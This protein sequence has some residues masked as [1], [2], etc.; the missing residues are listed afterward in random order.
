[1]TRLRLKFVDE[2]GA[3][4]SVE[5]DRTPF[6]IGRHSACDLTYTD[7][8]LSR[9][10]LR[11]D[12]EGDRFSVTD[13]GSSN[14]TALN[15]SKL[16][17]PADLSSGDE[18]DLGGGLQVTLE[19]ETEESPIE[20]EPEM[21][22]APTPVVETTVPQAPAPSS[23]GI[24]ASFFIIAPLLGL[25][26]LAIGITAAVLLGG[27]GKQVAA[28]PNDSGYT[29]DEDDPPVKDKD[30]DDTPKPVRSSTPTSANQTVN[31][32][33]ASTPMPGGTPATLPADLSET[34]KVEANGSAF[35][36]Q[37]AQNDP[38]AFL[39]S[40]Q[41]ARVNAKVKQI[42]RSSAIADNINS[43]R[44]NAAQIKTLA[45]QR[46]LKPQFLAA[47]AMTKLGG[48]RGDVLQAAQSI[49]DVYDKLS[50]QIGN[51]NF[52]DVLLLVAAYDQ[53]AA[54]ETMKMRNMLQA[55]AEQPGS[56][57]PREIR[58]IWYLQR[59]GKI[60]EA[61]YDRALSFLAIG[62][63]A[64]NPKEFGVNAEALRL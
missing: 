17:A 8:R 16:H 13:L 50:V 45:A 60:S 41:A 51:E 38:K 5:V 53:G 4:R 31:G 40:D 14:G 23:G 22:A 48:S 36:R 32:N 7:S 39:T 43:A 28:N 1:M 18:L 9:E 33:P 24:P 54:G 62:T 47:A 21:A 29:S 10:H 46:N 27:G 59:V 57:G 61:E 44:R 11:I 52:D 42:Q 63:I 55:L 19:V 25:F 30:E 64:Q 56:P 58:S 26:V 20:D 12:R 35:V 6:T 49:A 15:G 34:A 37:I 2:Y 3:E